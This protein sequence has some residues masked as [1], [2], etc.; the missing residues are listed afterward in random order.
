M[1]FRIAARTILHLGAELISSDGIALYELIKNAYDARSPSVQINIVMALSRAA[2][3][4]TLD[5][6]ADTREN[7]LSPSAQRDLMLHLRQRCLESI[8]YSA[9]CARDVHKK[10]ESIRTIDD[11]ESA[12]L[13]ANSISVIDQGEGMSLAILNDAFLTIG[14]RSKRRGKDA[15]NSDERQH[16]LGEKGIGRLSAMRLG[17][18]LRVRTAQKA[19]HRWNNLDIDWSAFSHASDALLEDIHLAARVGG[20]KASPETSGTE[21]LVRALKRDWSRK[22]VEGIVQQDLAQINDPFESSLRFPITVRHNGEIIPIPRLEPWILKHYH[23]RCAGKFRRLPSRGLVFSGTM[24]ESSGKT[25]NFSYSEVELLSV[26]RESHLAV[27]LSPEILHSLGPFSVEFYWFNRRKLT[28]LD[29]V[30]DLTT[31]RDRLRPWTG[32]LLV[33]RDGFRVFPYG[34][35]TMIGLIWTGR[36]SRAADTS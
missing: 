2:Q 22:H 24:D 21:I 30:G 33:F 6:I 27:D 11:L 26:A 35:G 15:M 19:D 28:A 16:T 4:D 32:G 9:P 29:G 36:P 14:T 23:G 18:R 3:R 13:D 17:D 7:Q 34:G 20:Q 31:V 10:L 8:D 12:V 25:E 5:R 1:S